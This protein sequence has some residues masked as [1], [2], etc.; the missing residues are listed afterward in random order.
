LIV[1]DSSALIALASI[2]KLDLL[3][4]LYGKV[5]IPDAVYEEVSRGVGR[6]AAEEIQAAEWVE[7]RTVGN[8][9]LV[10]SLRRELGPGESEAIVLAVELSAELLLID[11]KRGRAAAR[12]LGIRITGVLGAMVEAK[13]RGIVPSVRD[14]IDTL[15][16]A[17]PFRIGASLRREILRSVGEE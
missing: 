5:A 8:L 10:E 3:P 12:R 4:A 6:P 7:R 14:L 15:A 13:A 1:A 17:T 11:E 16:V 9:A 2:R